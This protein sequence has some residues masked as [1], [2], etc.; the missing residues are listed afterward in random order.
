M[1]EDTVKSAQKIKGICYREI[2]LRRDGLGY[3][4]APANASRCDAGGTGEVITREISGVRS[5]V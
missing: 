2:N 1:V 3:F 5:K 4:V